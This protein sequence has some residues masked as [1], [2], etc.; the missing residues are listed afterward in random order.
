MPAYE[1]STQTWRA[2]ATVIA[3]ASATILGLSAVFIRPESPAIYTWLLLA[4]WIGFIVAVV[5]VVLMLWAFMVSHET[6]AETS[7]GITILLMFISTIAFILGLVFLL[8]FAW[9]NIDPPFQSVES[10]GLLVGAIMKL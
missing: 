5:G 7:T 9:Q 6:R 8:L 4:S 1:E 10:S 3:G 2:L